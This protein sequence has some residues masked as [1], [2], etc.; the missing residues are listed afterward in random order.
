MLTNITD[1]DFQIFMNIDQYVSSEF[2]RYLDSFKE[3]A[4]VTPS[5]IV[6]ET[7]KGVLIDLDNASLGLFLRGDQGD[8]LMLE[9]LFN[10]IKERKS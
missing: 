4:R 7:R 10:Q 1:N 6:N 5:L 3:L 8:L 9:L 2:D